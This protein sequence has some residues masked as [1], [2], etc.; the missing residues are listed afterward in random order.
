M[1][2]RSGEEP[3]ASRGA[4]SRNDGLHP[5]DGGGFIP[6]S[7]IF[8]ETKGPGDGAGGANGGDAGAVTKTTWFDPVKPGEGP[9]DQP[10]VS[11]CKDGVCPVPW[12]TTTPAVVPVNDVVNQ[13]D[14]Y[15]MASIEC[16]EAIEAQLTPDEFRGY[17]KGNI[18]KYVWRERHKGSTES[19]KKAAWYLDRLIKFDEAH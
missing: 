4:T 11:E 6:V 19:L 15:T 16:I 14:H 9:S 1:R 13:P 2:A 18:A 3:T 17:M 7:S 12:L 10:V 8:P 5:L